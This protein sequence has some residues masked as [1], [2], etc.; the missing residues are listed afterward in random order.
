MARKPIEIPELIIKATTSIISEHA[1]A[2]MRSAK[3]KKYF[4]R[5]KYR[6]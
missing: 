1:Q 3:V 5:S 4:A 6:V 2:I